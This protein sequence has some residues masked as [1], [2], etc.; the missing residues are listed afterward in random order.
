MKRL[1]PL[2]LVLAATLLAARSAS[3]AAASVRRFVFPARERERK[4]K[5]N[6]RRSKEIK[7]ADS[8]LTKKL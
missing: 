8:R 7:N 5:G 4:S 6:S 3:V 1:V 2:L